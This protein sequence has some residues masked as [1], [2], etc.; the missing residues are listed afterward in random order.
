MVIMTDRKT[1]ATQR[2]KYKIQ[3]LET[4]KKGMRIV[5]VEKKTS[6]VADIDPA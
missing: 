3:K 5:E 2:R 1:P 6:C 4:K